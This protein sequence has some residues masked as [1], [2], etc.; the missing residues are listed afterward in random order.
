MKN[1]RPRTLTHIVAFGMRELRS[2]EL[3]IRTKRRR[4]RTLTYLAVPPPPP[5]SAAT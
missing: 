1:R 3:T 2:A 4:S 5:P